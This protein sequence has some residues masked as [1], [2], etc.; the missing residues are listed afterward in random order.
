MMNIWDTKRRLCSKKLLISMT[1]LVAS[2]HEAVPKMRNCKAL[3]IQRTPGNIRND[4][5]KC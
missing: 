5:G 2:G 3:N 4:Q 1:N